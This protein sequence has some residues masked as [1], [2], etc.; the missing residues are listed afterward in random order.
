MSDAVVDE[1]AEPSR[2]EPLKGRGGPPVPPSDMSPGLLPGEPRRTIRVFPDQADWPLWENSTEWRPSSPYTMSPADY[3]LTPELTQA[4]AAW[5]EIWYRHFRFDTGW[6]S[7][8]NEE[9]W[10]TLKEIVLTGL[11]QEVGEWADVRDET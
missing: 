4:I 10:S 9:A 11:R 6:D 3:Q 1:P 2:F 7:S 5:D 8:T